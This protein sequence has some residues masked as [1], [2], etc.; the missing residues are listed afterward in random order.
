MSEL[1]IFSSK[2]S[3]NSRSLRDFDEALRFIKEKKEVESAGKAAEMIDKLLAVINPI[4]D[5][6]N[7]NLSESMAINERSVIE[8]IRSRHEQEWPTY[9]EKILKLSARLNSK[10]FR[11]SEDDFRLLNDIAD[12]LDAECANLF[13]RMSDIR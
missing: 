6:I 8:I 13:R 5:V 4:T 11:L 9:R 1:G 12:A 7:G 10:R 2:F 3:V